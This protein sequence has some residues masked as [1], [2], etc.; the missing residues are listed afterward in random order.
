MV[1]IISKINR[2]LVKNII[3]YIQIKKNMEKLEMLYEGKAKQIFKTDNANEVIVRYKDDATAFNN[4]KKG[5]V[6]K[7]GLLNNEITCLIFDY[8]IEKGVETHYIKKLN[9]L[10]QLVQ[11]VDIVPLEVIVRNYIAGSMAKRLNIEEGTKSP[12]TIFDLCYKDDALGDPLIND[13]HAVAMGAASY[14]EINSIYAMTATINQHLIELF[15]KMNIILV[16]FK[17]ELGKNAAGKIILADEISPDTCRLWD[18]DTKKKLD[19]DRFRRDLGEVTE[20]Y[21]EILA[22]MKTALGK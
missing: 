8:L 11:K 20:A 15:D 16:D 17:I 7:K 19:K 4:L 3:N 18:K 9:D 2:K 6:E 14:E 13:H 12:V 10:E 21:E 5:Q 22:R 1:S